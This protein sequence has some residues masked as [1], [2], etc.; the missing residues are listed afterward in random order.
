MNY[1]PLAEVGDKLPELLEKVE[2]GEEFAVTRDGKTI[3]TLTPK[4]AQEKA[5]K[6]T[7]EDDPKRA[8]ARR[9]VMA[10]MEEGVHLGG[11]RIDREELYGRDNEKFIA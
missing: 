4:G 7:G 11:L 6:S 10:N 1:I 3:A 9:R 8:A 2:Q 5:D